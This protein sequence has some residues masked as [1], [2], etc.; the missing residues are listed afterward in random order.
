M[1]LANL[2]KICKRQDNT[3]TEEVQVNT[4]EAHR[5]S[6]RQVIGQEEPESSGTRYVNAAHIFTI[7]LI[8]ALS[9][10]ALGYGIFLCTECDRD[11]RGKSCVVGHSHNI[12][13]RSYEPSIA[14]ALGIF[15]MFI[16]TFV[17]YVGFAIGLVLSLLMLWIFT[18]IIWT[19]D[20]PEYLFRTSD[21]V[22]IKQTMHCNQVY[23]NYT[24]WEYFY[25]EYCP[26][27]PLLEQRLCTPFSSDCDTSGTPSWCE[28]NDY[29]RYLNL[30]S[31]ELVD[32]CV[33]R[34]GVWVSGV[35]LYHHDKAL[36]LMFNIDAV[37]MIGLVAFGCLA[38]LHRHMKNKVVLMSDVLPS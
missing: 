38:W 29:N 7:C 31:L 13:S 4:I 18:I 1:P 33:Q 28:K 14:L 10:A 17:G 2:W 25:E 5:S 9:L 27:L 36:S 35:F 37:Q 15:L 20:N 23:L 8:Y 12:C 32:D 34:Y 6:L 19:G 3:E 30:T 26:G 21:D 24:C 11:V 22:I 16:F